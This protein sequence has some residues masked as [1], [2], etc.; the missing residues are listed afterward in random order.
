[1]VKKHIFIYLE[2][3]APSI[4]G[5]VYSQLGVNNSEVL[6]VAVYSQLGVNNSEIFIDCSVLPTGS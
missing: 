3:L 4:D 1:V 2:K 6:D 5:A